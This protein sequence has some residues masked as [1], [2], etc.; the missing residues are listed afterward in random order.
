LRDW[1]EDQLGRVV[2]LRSRRMFGGVGFYADDL[3]FGF[4]DREGALY[5]KV[6]DASRAWY[7]SRGMEPF[8]ASGETM[9][10]YYQAPEG[11]L[12]DLDELRDRAQAAVE[13]ARRAKRR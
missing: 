13:A 4:L 3:F 12:E 10:S 5:L 7:E 1:V 9:S 6:D 11:L 2:K 8:L